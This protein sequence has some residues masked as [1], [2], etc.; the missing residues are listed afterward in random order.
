MNGYIQLFI[1]GKDRGF[2]FSIYVLGELMK[3]MNISIDQLTEAIKKDPINFMVSLLF[4]SATYNELKARRTPDFERIDMYDWIDEAGGLEGP[5]LIEFNKALLS[6]LNKDVPQ[7][8]TPGN[9]KKKR[10]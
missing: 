10:A 6:S 4:H 5:T 2:K 1:G 9:V 7:S 3:D 8:K